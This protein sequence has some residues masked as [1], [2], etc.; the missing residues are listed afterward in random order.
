MNYARFKT[1][2]EV[3][4]LSKEQLDFL[5]NDQSNSIG[6]LLLHFA[7]VEYA[8]QIET[9]EKRDFNEEEMNSIGT[10]TKIRK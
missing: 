7:A 3:R 10:S 6:A 2:E 1:L 4:S 9:F 5:F 8:Y